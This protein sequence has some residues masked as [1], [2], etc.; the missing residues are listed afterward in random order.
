MSLFFGIGINPAAA[1]AAILPAKPILFY[2]N[3]YLGS[4]TWSKIVRNR[5]A[6]L[7]AAGQS[8]MKS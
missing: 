2:S 7:A 3:C 6:A 8:G 1:R 5:I 4:E